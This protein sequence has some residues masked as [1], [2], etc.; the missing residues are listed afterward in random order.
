M[1]AET[2]ERRPAI[3]VVFVHRLTQQKLIVLDHEGDVNASEW[4]TA[5]DVSML[6]HRCRIQEVDTG[7]P[8]SEVQQRE[9]GQYL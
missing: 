4:F 3:G 8:Q 2:P 9:G 1:S 5:R 6:T 7:P